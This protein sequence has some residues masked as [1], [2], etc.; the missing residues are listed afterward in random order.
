VDSTSPTA[1]TP[2]VDSILKHGL[3]HMS[4]PAAAPAGAAAH[5]RTR[6]WPAVLPMKEETAP[7]LTAPTPEKLPLTV[8]AMSHA[9]TEQ[10]QQAAMSGLAF[11]ERSGFLVDAEGL[12]SRQEARDPAPKSAASATWR[13]SWGSWSG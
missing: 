10:Q 7:M 3:D 8:D 5:A 2:N 1:R 11:D 4:L 12:H 13:C 9:P 6:P